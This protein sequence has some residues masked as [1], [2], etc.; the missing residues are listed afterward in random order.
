MSSPRTWRSSPAY[1]PP[2][3]WVQ[4]QQFSSESLNQRVW[5]WRICWLNPVAIYLAMA[6]CTH[7]GVYRPDDRLHCC[8]DSS[9]CD[10]ALA[11]VEDSS[12]R[13]RGRRPT[14]RR[15]CSR[16][17]R[18]RR[19]R[20]RPSPERDRPDEAAYCSRTPPDLHRDTH[21]PRRTTLP[22]TSA[23]AGTLPPRF[24]KTTHRYAL[25]DWS[26]LQ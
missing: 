5:R 20:P 4:L 2:V 12:S 24:L 1:D 22:P 11:S 23:P 17:R 21:E 19:N 26:Q 15:T 25:I 13:A 8:A 7:C 18:C 3:F 9:A 6:C 10:R 14:R 16:S